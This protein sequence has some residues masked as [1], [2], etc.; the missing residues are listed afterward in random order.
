MCH[1]TIAK[2]LETTI[3]NLMGV[4]AD[5]RAMAATAG[6]PNTENTYRS[7]AQEVSAMVGDLKARL[8]TLIREEPQ[9]ASSEMI[10]APWEG[11]R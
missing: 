5:L 1:L 8:R 10:L 11:K 6:D 7:C 2:R 9:Y 4:Q 3:V